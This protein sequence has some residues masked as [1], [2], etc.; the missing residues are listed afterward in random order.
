VRVTALRF[1]VLGAA[2]IAPTALF[3]PARAVDGV[4]VR[5]IAARDPR[6]AAQ[7]AAKWRVP[8]V[9]ADYAAV[10]NDP[11][12]DAVYIPLPNSL[13]AQ[14]TLA[15]IRAGKH[16]LCEK[17]FTS[18]AVQAQAIAEAADAARA[19]DGV[20]VMEAFHYRYHPLMTRVLGLLADSVI[21]RIHHVEAELSFPLPKFSDIRY[22]LDLAGGALMDAGC[23]AVHCVRQLG[24]GEPTVV[25]AT[26]KLRSPGVDR[27]MTAWL[28]FPDGATGRVTC[29]MWSR[30]LLS[31]SAKA[32]GDQGEIRITNFVAPQIFNR[33]TVRTRAARWSERVA[34][35]P[36]Y[37]CQLRAFAAAVRDGAEV[38]TPP[39]DAVANMRVIDDCYLAAGLRPRGLL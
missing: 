8:T 36:T 11:A 20:V 38:L 1:G 17:P 15:A 26:A 5:A 16:V 9:H 19:A 33:L 21:G 2:S 14:W 25:D 18:N 27:A 12:V 24:S 4:E 35:E 30:R 32:V 10:I 3:K 31:V 6:R 23:Y 39:S 37:N 7:A 13:H 22:R 29:S 28:R 34:G